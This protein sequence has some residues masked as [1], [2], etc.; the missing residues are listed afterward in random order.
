LGFF[1]GYTPSTLTAFSTANLKKI[2][3]KINTSPFQKMD[4]QSKHI[5]S[6]F[7]A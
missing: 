5:N 2:N 3:Q 4:G 6:N 1:Y 7:T